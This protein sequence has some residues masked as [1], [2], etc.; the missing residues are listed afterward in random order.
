MDINN[1]L[2]S[3]RVPINTCEGLFE[4]LKWDNCELEQGYAGSQAPAWEPSEQSSSFA[5]R[6]AGASYTEFPSGS[7]GTSQTRR[8]RHLALRAWMVLFRPT[9]LF[10][11][12]AVALSVLSY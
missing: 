3:P 4:K 9:L 8:K 5:G 11:F 2:S 1:D 7:L 6:E 12:S 10:S